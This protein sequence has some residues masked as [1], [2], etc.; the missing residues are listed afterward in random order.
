M[1]IEGGPYGVR[2]DADNQHIDISLKNVYF[3]GPFGTATHL[4]QDVGTG[5]HTILE[6]DNVRHATIE[7]GVLIPGELISQP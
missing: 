3:V 2:I 6:W 4:I 7:D 5:T 1:I